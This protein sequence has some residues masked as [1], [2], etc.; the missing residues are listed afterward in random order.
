VLAAHPRLLVEVTTGDQS[1]DGT[2]VMSHA[3]RA[4]KARSART[5]F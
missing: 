5:G 4:Q 2:T 3:Q 1:Q